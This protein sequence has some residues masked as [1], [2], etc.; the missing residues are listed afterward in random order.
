MGDSSVCSPVPGK[1][2]CT[3]KGKLQ[4]EGG[5]GGEGKKTDRLKARGGNSKIED[6]KSTQNFPLEFIIEPM[7]YRFLD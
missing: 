4:G 3:M 1:E 2:M 5:G 7:R 6:S